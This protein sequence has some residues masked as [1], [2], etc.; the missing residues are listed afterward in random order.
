MFF[1]HMVSDRPPAEAVLRFQNDAV[2][3]GLAR[4]SLEDWDKSISEDRI[5]TKMRR[6]TASLWECADNRLRWYRGV[7]RT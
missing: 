1:G 7:G 5:E 6:D 3:I 2:L 4:C